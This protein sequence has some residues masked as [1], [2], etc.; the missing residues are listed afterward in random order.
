MST[1]NKT[2]PFVTDPSYYNDALSIGV[3]ITA[4]AATFPLP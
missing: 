1:A 3:G 4:N 2:N